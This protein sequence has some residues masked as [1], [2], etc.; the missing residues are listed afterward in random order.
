VK[1]SRISLALCLC[2]VILISARAGR[3]TL[4][5]PEDFQAGKFKA[6]ALSSKGLIV[7]GKDVKPIKVDAPIVWSMLEEGPDEVLLG[8][9]SRA[10]LLRYSGGEFE[11]VFEDPDKSRLAIT[12]I[13]R[14]EGGVIYF[15]AMPKG[16]IYKMQ[17]KEVKKF[18]EPGANYIWRLLPIANGSLLVAGGPKA[19]VYLVKPDGKS[20]KI[21]SLDAEQVMDIVDAGKGE[22]LAGTSRPALAV[23]FKLD[24]SYKVITAFPQEEVV[25]LQM[26]ADKSIIA[27]VNQGSAPPTPQ[28]VAPQEVGPQG[29]QQPRME[30]KEPTEQELEQMEEEQMTP[31]PQ[32]PPV[33]RAAVFQL[34]PDKGMKQI[35]ALK[36]G[37]ILSMAGNEKAGIY[38]GTDDQGRVYQIF[39]DREETRLSFDLASGRVISFAGSNGEVRWIG[40]GQPASLFKIEKGAAKASYQS[41]VLDAQFPARW[42]VLQWTG[43]GTVKFETRSGNVSQTNASWSKWQ[44]VGTGNPGVIASPNAKYL[45]FRANWTAEDVEIDRVEISYRDLNQTE[46]IAQFT[47]GPAASSPRPGQEQAQGQN[48]NGKAGTNTFKRLQANWRIDNPDADPLTQKLF[49]KKNNEKL[50]TVLAKDEDIK[51]TTFQWDASEMADGIYQ[52]KLLI[53]DAPNNSEGEAFSAEKIS[54]FFIVDSTKPVLTFKVSDKGGVSGEARDETSAISS[55]EYFVDDKDSRPVN[56]LDGVL[57]E[58]TE[59]FEFTLKDVEKGSHKLTMRACDQADNCSIVEQE[60]QVK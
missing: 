3:I 21:L 4:S 37:T 24:G 33:G 14:G 11:Q 10:R 36:Q 44:E 55:L 32:K 18:A 53:S 46:Y 8:A 20:E 28:M 38:L 13:V 23:S 58:R 26:L 59:K 6:S 56:S 54:D 60:F 19:V 57:D 50:W 22:Y 51:G 7:S 41:N 47:V 45:Q 52:F 27:A 30:V 17:G 49:Y 34:F 43:K 5:Q 48:K 12:Q 25:A 16:V 40:T 9:G 42:G 31:I 39:P 35:F 1:I 2:G 15:S 29:G